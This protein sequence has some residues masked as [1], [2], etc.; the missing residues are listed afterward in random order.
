MAGGSEGDVIG[1]G[2]AGSGAGV[3]G[4]CVP[5][6]SGSGVGDGAGCHGVR[7]AGGGVRLISVTASSISTSNDA[8]PLTFPTASSSV[9][10]R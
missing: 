4:V 10:G 2:T 3:A 5:G 8:R 7:S 1:P 9:T 6:V